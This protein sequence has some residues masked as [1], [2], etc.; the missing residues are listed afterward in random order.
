MHSETSWRIH[1]QTFNNNNNNNNK[2]T[3]IAPISPRRIELSGAPSTGVGQTH[4]PST[5]Q[6]SS[7]N[8]QMEWK[9]RKGRQVWKCEF[10]NG[11]GKKLYYLKA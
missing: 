3:S 2:K 1:T 10:S 5:M 6:S 11:D 9:L 7:T 4:S 8:D